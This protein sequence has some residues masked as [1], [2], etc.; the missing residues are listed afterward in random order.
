MYCIIAVIS[1]A[2]VTRSSTQRVWMGTTWDFAQKLQLTFLQI[3]CSSFAILTLK[4]INDGDSRNERRLDSKKVG[5]CN[6]GNNRATSSLK[7]ADT[8]YWNFQKAL[9]QLTLVWPT[10]AMSDSCFK[11]SNA[12]HCSR[13]A[14]PILLCQF[15][16]AHVPA[17]YLN[18]QLFP[19]WNALHVEPEV[20]W[21]Q[22]HASRIPADATACKNA[23]TE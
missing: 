20:S 4:G 19:P 8:S 17:I 2:G 9:I 22:I 13:L 1:C 5:D 6:F 7:Q 10:G 21:I 15:D 14:N 16:S 23:L 11:Q 18:L 12:A 3:N